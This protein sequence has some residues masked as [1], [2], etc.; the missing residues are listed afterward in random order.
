MVKFG[1]EEYVAGPTGLNLKA[2]QP[3]ATFCRRLNSSVALLMHLHRIR[4]RPQRL[5]IFVHPC[6]QYAT[7]TPFPR[8]VGAGEAKTSTPIAPSPLPWDRQPSF[9]RKCV[10]I[11]LLASFINTMAMILSYKSMDRE[12][13]WQ[14]KERIRTL[15]ETIEKVR[16]GEQIDIRA[17]LGTG[18]LE[19]EKK[20]N[21][22]TALRCILRTNTQPSL[23]RNRGTRK[24]LAGEGR[25]TECRLIADHG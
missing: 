21:D 8:V 13:A 9:L 1:A 15:R 10:N 11:L 22:G 17:A 4:C 5:Q 19:T 25:V 6:R 7:T 12:L 20:W 23:T 16:K 14:S 2:N 3:Q 18:D 24:D